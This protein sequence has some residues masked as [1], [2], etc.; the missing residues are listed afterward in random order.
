MPTRDV[1]FEPGLHRI[2]QGS[3]RAGVEIN[4][5]LKDAEARTNLVDLLVGKHEFFERS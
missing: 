5:A 1:V 2:G 3:L 4:F